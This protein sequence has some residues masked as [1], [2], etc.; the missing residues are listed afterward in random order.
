MKWSLN[1]WLQD[2]Y[3]DS[4]EDE[5]LDRTGDLAAKREQRKARLEKKTEQVETYQ[6]LKDKLAIAEKAIHEINES[7]EKSK[8]IGKSFSIF[9]KCSLFFPSNGGWCSQWN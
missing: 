1:L 8:A 4:E 3:Y 5:F 7:L 2:D 9:L 6:S